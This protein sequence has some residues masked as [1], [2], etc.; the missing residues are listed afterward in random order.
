MEFKSVY[1]ET[2]HSVA[3]C[4]EKFRCQMTPEEIQRFL[5]AFFPFLFGIYPYTVVTEKPEDTG[6]GGVAL[7]VN[8]RLFIHL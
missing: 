3:R 1:R 2:L 5:Y 4:L 6:D 8:L 7:G